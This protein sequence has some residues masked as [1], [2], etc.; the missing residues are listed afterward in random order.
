MKKTYSVRYETPTSYCQAVY[1]TENEMYADLEVQNI[2]EENPSILGITYFEVTSENDTF[3]FL[4]TWDF[5]KPYHPRGLEGWK[6]DRHDSLPI[7][8]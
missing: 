5:G 3:K 7:P 6:S 8:A 4:R 2:V 1:E